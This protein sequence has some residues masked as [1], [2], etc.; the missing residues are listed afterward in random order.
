[1]GIFGKPPEGKPVEPL[2]PP[3]VAPP[4]PAPAPSP[5]PGGTCLI[6]S[7][8]TVKGEITGDEDILVEGVVEGQIRISRDLRVGPGGVVKANVE[9]Q[10]VVVSGELVGDC[11]ASQRVEIQATGR[12]TGNIRSPRVVIA[13]GATFKGNSDMSGR[14]DVV[15]KDEKA[16]A[17]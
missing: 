11:Q 6:G 1:M 4:A 5:R 16:A 10:S 8:T 3:R 12:L 14:K 13:E 15:R 9:A 17:S 7:K 2:T